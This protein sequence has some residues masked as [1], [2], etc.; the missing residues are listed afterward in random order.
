MSTGIIILGLLP[1]STSVSAVMD[2]LFSAFKMATRR[3][4]QLVYA[5]KIK[6]NSRAVRLKK[7]QISQRRARNEEIPASELDKVNVV[8]ML[9]PGDLGD[10][11]YCPFGVNEFLTSMTEISAE[12]LPKNKKKYATP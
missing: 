1:N 11:L 6:A 7:L 4:T 2:E 10:I 3:S 12:K 8:T 9:N 5:K